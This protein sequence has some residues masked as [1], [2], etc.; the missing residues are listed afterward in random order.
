MTRKGGGGV[1]AQ[2]AELSIK[3]KSNLLRGI[4]LVC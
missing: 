4:S 1:S 2:L 3:S